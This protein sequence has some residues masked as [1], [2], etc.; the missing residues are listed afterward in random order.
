M[1]HNKIHEKIVKLIGYEYIG[2]YKCNEIT[3]DKKNKSKKEI[4]IRIVCPYCKKIYDVSFSKFKNGVRCANCCNK[5]EDSFAY[6][7]QQELKEPLN[8]Y[9]DWDKNILNP[10]LISKSSN[11]K[12]WIKCD[13]TDYH[14][15]YLTRCDS[16]N[17]KHRCPYCSHKKVHPKDSFAQWGINNVDKDFLIKYWSSKNTLNPWKLAPQSSKRVWILCQNKEYHNDNSGYSIRCDSFYRGRRCNYC[18]NNRG[19]VHL[20]DSFGY[21]HS[22]KAKYWSKS[23]SKSPFEV[24]PYSGKIFKF[25]CEDCGKEFET[26]LNSISQNVRSMKCRDCTSSKGE[27]KIKEYLIKNN[28]NFI[29]QKTFNEL[30]GVRNSLLSYDFYL[31]KYNLLIEYQGEQHEKYNDFF[32]KRVENFKIQ[33]EHDER[34]R[35]YAKDNNIKL[36]EIWYYNFNDIESILLSTLNK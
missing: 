25:Y 26:S 4:Y 30:K 22:Q 16:F 24:A 35:R 28:I 29:P 36:L 11:K 21:L 9:W 3:I 10:Y 31:P 12:V 1:Y 18:S 2:S 19:K 7:I 32:Y 6:Y 14:G 15:S 33:L 27:Q 20:K 5:Y 34:K 8:R 23:N 13:K 17:D